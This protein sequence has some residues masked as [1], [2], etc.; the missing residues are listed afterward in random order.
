[1]LRP[2]KSGCPVS[3]RTELVPEVT[4]VTGTVTYLR[5]VFCRR[6]QSFNETC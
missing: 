2:P 1:M 3:R 6:M 4:A 5:G